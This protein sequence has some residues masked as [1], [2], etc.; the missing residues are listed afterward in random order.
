MRNSFK[1]LRKEFKLS[2]P[3]FVYL[4]TG[5]GL[6]TFIPGYP[7]LCGA[8]FVCLGLFQ[9]YQYARESNDIMYSVLLPV[10]KADIVRAKYLAAF[11]MEML[12]VLL[13]VICTVLRMTVMSEATVYEKNV[14]MPANLVFLAFSLLIFAAF[15]VIFLGGFFKTAYTIGRPFIVFIVVGFVVIGIGETLHHVPGLPFPGGNGI[16]MM[17][18]QVTVLAASAVIYVIATMISCRSS[19]RRFEI[20][21]L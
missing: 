15:N 2:I 17:G 14:L 9:G 3:V 12:A 4:F 6:M 21:D 16:G 1:L 7:I 20:I 11:I 13:M 5:F 8:F 19:E 18:V 10:R